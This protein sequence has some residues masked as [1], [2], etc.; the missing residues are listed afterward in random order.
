MNLE[1]YPVEL[2]ICNYP[3]F[4]PDLEKIKGMALD[5]LTIVHSTIDDELLNSLDGLKFKNLTLEAC[6]MTEEGMEVLGLSTLEQATFMRCCVVDP[7]TVPCSEE[8]LDN[9]GILKIND[10]MA[11]FNPRLRALAQKQSLIPQEILKKIDASEIQKSTLNHEKIDPEENQKKLRKRFE[12]LLSD[13]K[14]ALRTIKQ[15]RDTALERR[16]TIPQTTFTLDSRLLSDLGKLVSDGNILNKMIVTAGCPG[17]KIDES[18]FKIDE[19]LLKSMIQ[20]KNSISRRIASYR[21][22]RAA[23]EELHTDLL[24][25]AATLPTM[26]QQ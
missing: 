24:S 2:A 10:E 3:A 22:V 4:K 17:F 9:F 11:F 14:E 23:L 25:G 5:R 12:N 15:L 13:T 26:L 16:L 20:L 1:K 19:S 21:D 6:T 18:L 8:V 7:F